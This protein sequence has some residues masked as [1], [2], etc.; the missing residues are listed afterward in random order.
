MQ[1]SRSERLTMEDI[2]KKLIIGMALGT[3]AGLL[4]GECSMVKNAMSKGK[5]KIKSMIS[6]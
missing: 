2:M 6:K 1:S 4:L 3:A 5:K